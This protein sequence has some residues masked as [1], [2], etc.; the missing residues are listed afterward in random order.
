MGLAMWFWPATPPC[1]VTLG[2]MGES[3][4]MDTSEQV[5]EFAPQ[6]APG[7]VGNPL[8]E[9]GP[10]LVAKLRK[11]AELANE[12]C[13]RAMALAHKLAMQIRAAEARIYQLE[14]E[15]K[16]YQARDAGAEK[17]LQ[18]IKKEIEDKFIAP[19]SRSEQSSLHSERELGNL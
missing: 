18:L 14:A 3:V 10:V 16:Q 9:P 8:V 19:G 15:L 7:G 6:E 11:A 17:W 5:F 13:D 4:A 1:L 12:N 2:E